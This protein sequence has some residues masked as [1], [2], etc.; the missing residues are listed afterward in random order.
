MSLKL[1]I[2]LSVVHLHERRRRGVLLILF[3]IAAFVIIIHKQ[4]RFSDQISLVNDT[5]DWHCM[6]NA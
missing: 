5:K 4:I 3:A 1:D 6:N 2:D